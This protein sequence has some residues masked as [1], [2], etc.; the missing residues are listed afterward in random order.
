MKHIKD[1]FFE[2]SNDG[3]YDCFFCRDINERRFYVGG[4]ETG[5]WEITNYKD[6]NPISAI[7]ILA[8]IEYEFR[9][10]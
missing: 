3:L 1:L 10:I 6:V 5:E 7:E 8:E 9:K 2:K 4:N